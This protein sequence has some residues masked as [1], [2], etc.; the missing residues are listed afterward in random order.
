LKDKVL[1]RG[2]CVLTLGAKTTNYPQADVLVESGKVAEIGTGLR[3]RDA[4]VIDATNTIVMPG[5]VDTHR[6]AW[7]SL[8]RNLGET[9]SSNG[10]PVS[11]TIYGPHHQPEDVYAATLVGL[12]GAAEAG[13]TTVVDWSD[14][15]PQPGHVD[16]ALEAH[17]DSGLRTVFVHAMPGWDGRQEDETGG[18]KRLVQ[19]HDASSVSATP[20]AFGPRD[21]SR[22]DL[23][24]VERE[25]SLARELGL[26]IHT[27][28]GSEPADR[29]VI[30]DL[31]Q[32]GLLGEDVTL[33]HCSLLDNADLDA[34]AAHRTS[35][36]LAPAS[37]MAD[38]LGMPP[39]QQ[40][41]DRGIRPGLGVD[42][43]RVTPGDIFAQM[44]ATN[45]V[46]HAT[47]FDLKLAGKGGLPNLLTTREVIRFATIDG[48][49]VAGLGNVTGS[50]EAG[51]E[52][53]IVVLR[54]D[55][56]NIWPINDPIGAVVW[57]MDTSNVDW[58]FSGGRA[59]VRNGELTAD[60]A[61]VRDLSVAARERVG[62][63]SGLMAA[64]GGAA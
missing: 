32:R 27:H 11:A 21:P 7:K 45:S 51:K 56:P 49:R 54:T 29:G 23:D 18:L 50:L 4:E 63:A 13:I 37:E 24:R 20:I 48:A 3:S 31:A 41:I 19:E 17:H 26:R 47:H 53:D 30:S 12:V 36:S 9:G 61:R 57:G 28:V 38:G 5:F 59:L 1:I 33:I 46:Q 34:I 40:L 15:P 2:G 62:E 55:R 8:F 43:D 22:L 10:I 14:I 52:A 44:R 42:S 6:H 58:V 64:S 16:A 25:W 39:I 35:V 60:V